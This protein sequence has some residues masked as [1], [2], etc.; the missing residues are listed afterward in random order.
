MFPRQYLCDSFIRNA[1]FSDAHLSGTPPV[2]RLQ[3]KITS[4]RDFPFETRFEKVQ[5]RCSWVWVPHLFLEDYSTVL[6]GSSNNSSKAPLFHRLSH[7]SIR[8]LI[9]IGL[10]TP[11]TRCKI[12]IWKTI[13]LSAFHW[14][15]WIPSIS[16]ESIPTNRFTIRPDGM[17]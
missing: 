4:S 6:W 15:F 3:I 12:T 10:D 1:Q 7:E 17:S 2:S 9:F 13:T 14:R 5:W 16:N 11:L 8:S